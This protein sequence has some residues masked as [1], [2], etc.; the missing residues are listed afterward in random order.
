MNGVSAPSGPRARGRPGGSVQTDARVEYR[1]ENVHDQVRHDDEG[2][3]Q[4]RDAQDDGQVL[5][6]DRLDGGPA[7]SGYAEERLHDEDSAERDA[8]VEA[9]QGNDGSE[10]GTQRVPRD[11]AVFAHSLGPGGPDVI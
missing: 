10:R 11:Q 6:V 5:H 2:R 8:D 9:G 4:D 7:E 3:G 1:V